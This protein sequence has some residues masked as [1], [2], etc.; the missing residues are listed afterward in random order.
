MHGVSDISFVRVAVLGNCFWVTGVT[1]MTPPK[2][3]IGISGDT[4]VYEL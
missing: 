1:M 3:P 2:E 4:E